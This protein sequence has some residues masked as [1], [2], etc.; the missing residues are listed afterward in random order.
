MSDD[1][2]HVW[3]EVLGRDTP[4]LEP[5]P[6]LAVPEAPTPRRDSRIVWLVVLVGGLVYEL[7]GVTNGKVGDTLTE[8]TRWVMGAPDALRWW[9]I[10]CA[11]VGLAVWFVPH[12]VDPV[13]WGWRQL[14]SIWGGCAVAALLLWLAN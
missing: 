9:L 11:V 14:L 10:L 8:S 3:A 12:L 7:W 5:V 1:D 2:R 13:T 6:L 4:E